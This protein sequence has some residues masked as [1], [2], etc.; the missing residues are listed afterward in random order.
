ML[1]LSYFN[2]L[3]NNKNATLGYCEINMVTFRQTINAATES[4][5]VITKS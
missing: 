3:P 4:K 5:G 1:N 2:F